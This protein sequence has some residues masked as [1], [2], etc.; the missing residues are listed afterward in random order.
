MELINKKMII[1]TVLVIFSVVLTGCMSSNTETFSSKENGTEYEIVVDHNKETYDAYYKFNLDDFEGNELMDRDS[2]IEFSSDMLCGMIY[3]YT[4][5][6]KNFTSEM[7]DV[8][9]IDE[10][11]EIPRHIFKDYTAKDLLVEIYNSD[12]SEKL[13]YCENK[14]NELNIVIV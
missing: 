2:M 13:S 12:G 14:D 10:E 8:D 11:S 5:E 4:Y 3:K 9:G 6:N 7:E 1:I